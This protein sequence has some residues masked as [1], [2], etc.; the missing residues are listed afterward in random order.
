MAVKSAMMTTTAGL[1]NSDGSLSRDYY[2]QGA[3]NAHPSAMFDPGLIFESGESDWLSF[4][5]AYGF[6]YG[7]EVEPVDPSDYNSPSIAIGRLAGRQ[8]VTRKVTAVKTGLY[9]AKVW[10]DGVDAKVTPS[11]LSFTRVGQ[12]KSITVTLTRRSAPLR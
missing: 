6:D 8:T 10:V 12:T 2:A 3:G 4:L 1:K 11:L 7:S 9:Q 5:E